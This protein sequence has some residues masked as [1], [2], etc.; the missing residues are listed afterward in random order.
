MTDVAVD[1]V[2]IRGPHARRLTRVAAAAL[3]A[4]LERALAKVDDVV[5]ERLT[6][7]LD[8]DPD[9]L[10]DETLAL[11][12]AD[13]ILAAVLKEHGSVGPA[14]RPRERGAASSRPEPPRTYGACSLPARAVFAEPEDDAARLLPAELL[15]LRDPTTARRVAA[16]LGEGEWTRLVTALER[17][18]PPGTLPRGWPNMR[19]RRRG[20][21]RIRRPQPGVAGR[22]P[23]RTGPA[24]DQPG[25]GAGTMPS[26]TPLRPDSPP[27]G[28]YAALGS[29]AELRENGTEPLDLRAVTAV[30]GL[31]LFYPWL[32]DHCRRAVELHPRLDPVDVREAAL[33]A[34]AGEKGYADDPL[35]RLLAGRPDPLVGSSRLRVGL[36]YEDEVA[37]SAE[38]VIRSF[39]ALLPGFERSSPEFVRQA[40]LVRLGVIDLDRSPALLTA[41]T[42]PLDVALSLLPYP[43][44]LTKLP[45]MPPLSM[46]FRP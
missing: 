15:L 17:L 38:G 42:H 8:V 23:D 45:W 37:E 12:W 5:V 26:A 19:R 13:A 11:L 35:V 14:A 27:T 1:R 6:V 30:A 4:A 3:P 24:D 7:V 10:D 44:G 22:A 36:P 2:R 34:V 9:Q 39:A 33:A 25:V 21:R 20:P 41:A 31:V 18:L 32:A 43:R 28:V 46:R 40:W 16:A 29:L